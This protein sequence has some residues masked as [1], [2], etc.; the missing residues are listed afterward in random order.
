MTSDMVPGSPYMTFTFAAATPVLN[1][2]GGTITTINNQT[3]SV[4]K[5]CASLLFVM[6]SHA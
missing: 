2:L 4:N 1:S 3:I 6:R 5:I